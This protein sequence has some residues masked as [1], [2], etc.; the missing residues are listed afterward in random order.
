MHQGIASIIARIR[1]D[2]ATH[3]SAAVIHKTCKAVGQ[4]WPLF[5]TRFHRPSP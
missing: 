3:L 5:L 2:V 4:S 1:Q